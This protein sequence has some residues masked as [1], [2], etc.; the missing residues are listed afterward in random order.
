MDGIG[1]G[2]LYRSSNSRFLP[3]SVNPSL[4][5]FTMFAAASC[6]KGGGKLRASFMLPEILGRR[7]PRYQA[8]PF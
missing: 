5:I 6:Q 8:L 2:T 4:L 7:K 1:A 3:C